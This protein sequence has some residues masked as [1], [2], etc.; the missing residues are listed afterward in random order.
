MVTTRRQSIR[1]PTPADDFDD[2][3]ENA[4]QNVVAKRKSADRQ[5]DLQQLAAPEDVIEQT[6]VYAKCDEAKILEF[7]SAIFYSPKY[8]C[9]GFEYRCV[10]VKS[11]QGSSQPRH[12]AQGSD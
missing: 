2:N 4:N 6:Y 12:S 9:D 11:N 5:R 10:R 8:F 1:I 3:D 7:I